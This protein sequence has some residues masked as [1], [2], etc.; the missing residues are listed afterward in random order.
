M[1]KLAILLKPQG[2][3]VENWSQGGQT[4][5]GC[6]RNVANLQRRLGRA[7]IDDGDFLVIVELGGNDRLFGM[8]PEQIEMALAQLVQ[9]IKAANAKPL[10][11]EVIPDGIERDVSANCGARLIRCPPDIAA[12]IKEP[13]QRGVVPRFGH[14][15]LQPDGIHPNAKA[16]PL[17]LKEVLDAVALEL[18]MDV[19]SLELEKASAQTGCMMM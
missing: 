18:S 10:F 16:Q 7:G 19:T 2:V 13:I 17:I 12:T 11:M 15:Y 4:A 1:N 8:P 5:T 9:T 14:K 6:I 3:K